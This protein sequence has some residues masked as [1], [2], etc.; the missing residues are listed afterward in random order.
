MHKVVTFYILQLCA[1]LEL[2]RTAV[3]FGW[4]LVIQTI[5]YLL[6]DIPAIYSSLEREWRVKEN[7]AVAG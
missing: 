2:G 1:Q 5:T 6:G 7:E 4:N 3:F